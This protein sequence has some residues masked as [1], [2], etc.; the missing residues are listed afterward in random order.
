MNNNTELNLLQ[1]KD[2]LVH[3]GTSKS[4]EGHQFK[5]ETYNTPSEARLPNEE[6]KKVYKEEINISNLNYFHQI[7]GRKSTNINRIISQYGVKVFYPK[8]LNICI[9]GEQSA[10][11]KAILDINQKLKKI[12]NETVK[13]LNIEKKY[14]SYFVDANGKVRNEITTSFKNVRIKIPA[15]NN[16]NEKIVLLGS[17]N[18]VHACANHLN[19]IIQTNYSE[20]MQIANEIHLLLMEKSGEFINR[21]Q[22]ETQTCL[23]ISDKTFGQKWILISGTKENVRRARVLVEENLK[24]ISVQD[25]FEKCIVVKPL[26]DNFRLAAILSAKNEPWHID[27]KKNFENVNFEKN[28]KE[29]KITPKNLASSQTCNFILWRLKIEQTMNTYL[30]RFYFEIIE[31]DNKKQASDIDELKAKIDNI[32]NLYLLDYMDKRECGKFYFAGPQVNVDDFA[33]RNDTFKR[34]SSF[35]QQKIDQNE[36]IMKSVDVPI[37]ADLDK[38]IQSS[39]TNKILI[40]IQKIYNLKDYSLNLNANRI[41]LHGLRSDVESAIDFL[42]NNLNNIHTK[43][44]NIDLN[45]IPGKMEPFDEYLKIINDFLDNMEAINK[46]IYKVYISKTKLFVAYFYDDSV[47]EQINSQIIQNIIF[48]NIDVTKYE[49]ILSTSK[50]KMFKQE[51]FE[52]STIDSN[53]LYYEHVLKYGQNEIYLMGKKEYL[54]PAKLKILAVLSDDSLKTKILDLSEDDVKNDFNSH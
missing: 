16:K 45:I 50:W 37:I 48:A 40:S 20:K 49:N 10:V 24:K 21:I 13:C 11:K 28:E 3:E 42:K 5:A 6:K 43:H 30:N 8:K 18:D 12:E 4:F 32:R 26:R 33:E 9:E 27:F 51:N 36:L 25:N 39:L 17:A 14:H 15:L 38:Q 35:Y 47:F 52:N 29:L 7:I 31:Y 41:E 46:L 44:V 2:T 22:N 19:Y 1:Q 23:E 53:H 54:I 34:L